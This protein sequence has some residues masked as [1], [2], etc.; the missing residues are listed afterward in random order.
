MR[1]TTSTQ[2]VHYHRRIIFVWGIVAVIFGLCAAIW[3]SVARSTLLYFFG[4]FFVVNGLVGIIAALLVR[5]EFPLWWL[6]VAAGVAS[7]LL[8]IAVIIRPSFVLLLAIWAI[9]TGIFELAVVIGHRGVQPASLPL[10]AGVILII[11]GAF[12]FVA[13]S[14]GALL[15]IIWVIGL[16][17]LV[18]G[19][20]LILRAW[21]FHPRPRAGSSQRDV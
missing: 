14:L 21:L 4:I 3:P 17:T 19:G 11:L 9:I 8:G 16:Y 1:I 7:I 18:Y 12:F 5:Q 6:Q 20:A 15:A 2:P 13:N 10:A